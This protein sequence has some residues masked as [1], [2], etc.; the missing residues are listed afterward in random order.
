[1]SHVSDPGRLARREL[2]RR[3]LGGLALLPLGVAA[4]RAEDAKAEVKIDNFAF[5]PAVLKVKK[6]TEVTW[7]NEDD[8][9]HTVVAVG[10]NL[11][12]KTLDTD[13]TFVYRFDKV[14]TFNYICALHPHMKGQ[15]VV[16]G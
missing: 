13:Q 11:R 10:S 7:T 6:G 3:V 2:L 15:V 4:V 8:I 1:M 14:G 12:S 16:S 9:P 5:S